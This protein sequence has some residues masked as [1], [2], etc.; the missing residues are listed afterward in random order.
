MPQ[1]WPSTV[2]PQELTTLQ[3]SSSTLGSKPRVALISSTVMSLSSPVLWPPA[4]QL[5]ITCISEPLEVA[6]ISLRRIRILGHDQANQLIPEGIDLLQ[7]VISQGIGLEV[8]S[9]RVVGLKL[10]QDGADLVNGV[11]GALSLV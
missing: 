4:W 2:K 6:D 10:V 11:H 3:G 8:H 7:E 1:S 5:A 9:H